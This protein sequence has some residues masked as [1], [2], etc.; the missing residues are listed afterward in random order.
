M[1]LISQMEIV[2]NVGDT[3]SYVGTV[4]TTPIQIPGV[5]GSNINEMMVHCPTQTPVTA[6][7]YFSFDGV[8]YHQLS[9]GE[10]L[11]WPVKGSK[12]QIYVKA[13]VAGVAYEVILN[14]DQA[15]E[16]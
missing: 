13:S 3:T 2:D 7:L 1:D 8:A 10:A 9:T 16:I 11:M 15:G 6:L 5:A 12:K 14:T 4:G